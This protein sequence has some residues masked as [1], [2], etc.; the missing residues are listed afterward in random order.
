MSLTGQAEE[1]SDFVQATTGEA[2]LG[3]AD[4]DMAASDKLA[5]LDH[6][7]RSQRHV[8]ETG[9]GLCYRPCWACPSDWSLLHLSLLL[10]LLRLPLLLPRQ[11]H[12]LCVVC[13]E[14]DQCLAVWVSFPWGLRVF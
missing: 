9:S 13:H 7:H 6:S 4:G 12:L 5:C 11:L 3:L 2:W 10:R 1:E 14:V 8:C